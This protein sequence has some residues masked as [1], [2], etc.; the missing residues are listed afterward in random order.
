MSQK[1]IQFRVLDLQDLMSVHGGTH[2]N[3]DDAKAWSTFSE[4]CGSVGD[5][6]WSTRSEGCAR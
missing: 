6:E 5:D 2:Q 1:Q 4:N 3:D